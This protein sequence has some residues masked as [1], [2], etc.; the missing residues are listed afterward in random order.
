MPLK[1]FPHRRISQS[2]GG[3]IRLNVQVSLIRMQ[4]ADIDYY[5]GTVR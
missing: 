4:S 1:K 5:K 3:G 2:A